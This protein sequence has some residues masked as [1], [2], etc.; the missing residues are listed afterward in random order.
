M[1][2]RIDCTTIEVPVVLR[3]RIARHRLHG[4]QAYYEVVEEAL[5]WW[6]D[7]GGWGVQVV[8]DVPEPLSRLSRHRRSRAG[9]D[10]SP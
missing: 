8:V 7:C 2:N 10:A 6:E 5:S 9:Q 1:A 4:R 3:D